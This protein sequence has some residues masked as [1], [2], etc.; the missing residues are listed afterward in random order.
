MNFWQ[1]LTQPTDFTLLCKIALYIFV[2][3]FCWTHLAHYY[4]RYR[5]IL[6]GGL[7]HDLGPATVLN[8]NF[9]YVS[10]YTIEDEVM[11]M[12]ISFSFEFLAD[13][14]KTVKLLQDEALSEL[15]ANDCI[16]ILRENGML[17]I[18]GVRFYITRFYYRST[19]NRKV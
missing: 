4:Y 3:V 14:I 13:E 19:L 10:Y 16:E 7:K 15:E 17:A 11:P 9:F 2:A 12:N 6:T 1:W 18:N 5:Y 8:N